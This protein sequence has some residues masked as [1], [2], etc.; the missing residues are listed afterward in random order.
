MIGILPS[1]VVEQDIA[2]GSLA[3]VRWELP[4]P[5]G[6]VGVSY[7]KVKGLSPAASFILDELRLVGSDLG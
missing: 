2:A 6:P 1:H 4:I 7:R 3:K 5:I